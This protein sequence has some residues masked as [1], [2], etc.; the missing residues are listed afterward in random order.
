MW[1]V[2]LWPYATTCCG[3]E[4]VGLNKHSFVT[5]TIGQYLLGFTVRLVLIEVLIPALSLAI[6]VN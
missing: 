2:F 5:Q 3:K 1:Q 6:C 4:I